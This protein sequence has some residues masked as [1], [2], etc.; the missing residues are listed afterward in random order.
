M[1]EPI[2]QD[3]VQD[4]VYHLSQLLAAADQMIWDQPFDSIDALTVRRLASL[5]R[6]AMTLADTAQ[7]QLNLDFDALAREAAE[8]EETA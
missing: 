3:S 7:R 6:I 5:I 2:S 8:A 4:D 1:A